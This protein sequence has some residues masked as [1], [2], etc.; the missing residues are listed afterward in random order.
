[1]Q[2]YVFKHIWLTVCKMYR[3]SEDEG[4]NAYK[5][6]Y[7]KYYNKKQKTEQEKNLQNMCTDV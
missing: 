5:Y 4:K 2:S 6:K 7:Y 3:R 1:M